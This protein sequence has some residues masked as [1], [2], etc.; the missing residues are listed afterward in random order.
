MI[1]YF[2]PCCYGR[3]HDRQT[4]LRIIIETI[5][6]H[7]II[8]LCRIAGYTIVGSPAV[9]AEIQRNPDVKRRDATK[10]FFLQTADRIIRPSADAIKRARWLHEQ[11]LGAMDSL[12]LAI[13]ET[14][15]ADVLITVDDGF[16]RVCVNKKLSA[17][18]VINP[19]KFIQ[20]V[21]NEHN[22]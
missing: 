20:E 4:H 18:R 9:A 22:S 21:I 10:D 15:G 7:G 1:I 12:H 14:A 11:G 17:V 2:D 6:I 19:L 16:E 5:A 13:A 3:E 8:E